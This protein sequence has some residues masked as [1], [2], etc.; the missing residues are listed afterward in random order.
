MGAPARIPPDQMLA[1]GPGEVRKVLPG[2]LSLA[3]A[4]D[5]WDDPTFPGIK[6]D[7][8][9][10]IVLPSECREWILARLAAKRALAAALA[11]TSHSWSFALDP[12]AASV[13]AS[14]GENATENTLPCPPASATIRQSK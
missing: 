11:P 9:G 8:L 5:L 7:R 10:P 2:G 12:A 6:D 1:W 13:S 3:G 4:T 14:S